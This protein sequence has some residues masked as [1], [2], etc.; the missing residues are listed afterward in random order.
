VLFA[1]LERFHR[2]A[3][4]RGIA[5]GTN[6]KVAIQPAFHQII[7]SAGAHG[8]DSQ[9]FI[10]VA[11]ENDDGNLGRFGVSANQ[12]VQAVGVWKRQI[13]Q[14]DVEVFVAQPFQRGRQAVHMNQ[15][16]LACAG[17]AHQLGE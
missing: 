7:L 11:G 2:A 15:V 17:I 14:H 5:Y 4:L 10:I 16:P 1:A 13:Q 6:Q 3:A 12:C 9:R 8:T